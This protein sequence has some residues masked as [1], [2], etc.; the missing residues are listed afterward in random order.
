MFWARRYGGN[1][2]NIPERLV[3]EGH[4]SEIGS[5]NYKKGDNKSVELS[6][7]FDLVKEAERLGLS[8]HVN[9]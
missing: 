1:V 8:E 6:L 3:S 4:C 2:H 7:N 9:S 5:K